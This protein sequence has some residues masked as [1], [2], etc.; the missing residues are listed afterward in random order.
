MLGPQKKATEAFT[1]HPIPPRMSSPHTFKS[2][3]NHAKA[4]RRQLE[5]D[6]YALTNRSALLR[7]QEQAALIRAQQL[8]D[9]AGKA[10][11]SHAHR[12]FQ[13]LLWS[14]AREGGQ[15]PL[16]GLPYTAGA[17]DIAATADLMA[18]LGGS[19]G[20][21]GQ[22]PGGVPRDALATLVASRSAQAAAAGAELA[23]RSPASA[24][25]TQPIARASWVATHKSV[26]EEAVAAQ[27]ALTA[28]RRAETGVVERECALERKAARAAARAAR[29]ERDRQTVERVREEEARAKAEREAHA[30]EVARAARLEYEAQVQAELSVLSELSA[31]MVPLR[32]MEAE[33]ADRARVATRAQAAAYDELEH[34]VTFPPLPLPRQQGVEDLVLAA[35][36]AAAALGEGVLIKPLGSSK[37]GGWGG[38]WEGSPPWPPPGWLLAPLGLPLW[39]PPP[40]LLPPLPASVPLQTLPW[41]PPPWGVPCTFSATH[42]SPP[43]PSPLHTPPLVVAP[44]PPQM[45]GSSF[46]PPNSLLLGAS[47][48]LRLA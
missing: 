48:P 2:S 11:E 24:P 35:T 34:S 3:K 36:A 40:G 25:P 14:A 42:A 28:A 4:L 33:L 13:A 46:L 26:Q 1:P 23:L 32:A 41:V 31:K 38:M 7:E 30:A 8:R 16:A 47:P 15:H 37:G 18:T 45:P 27:T 10:A 44:F 12:G 5:K 22:L 39:P 29:L 21:Q 20:G 9:R 17:L 43:P 6:V 19:G